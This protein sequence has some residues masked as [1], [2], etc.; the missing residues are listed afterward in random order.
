MNNLLAGCRLF[1]ALAH[2]LAG[3]FILYAVFPRLSARERQARVQAWSAAMLDCLGIQLRLAGAPIADR[4]TLIAANHSSWLDITAIHAACY[5]R[6]VSKGEV[7]QWPIVGAMAAGA[8]TLFITRE[9]RRD[10]LR[11]VHH[12]A[13]SL[14]SGDVVA[15]FPEGTTS[16]G[17][18]LLPFHANLFQAAI[19]AD[20]PVQPVAITFI[21]GA[22][23]QR[24][25]A[26][27]YT[28]NDTL[29]GSVWRTLCT[30]GIA[31]VIRFGL[32]QA[33]QGRDR[34]TWAANVRATVAVLQKE[35]V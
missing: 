9:S 4:G 3:L 12:M 6:F 33:A 16:D 18:H 19:S 8:G 1:R 35:S 7:R 21:D 13:D 20:A 11:V 27:R 23:G 28:D 31:V 17:R 22:T 14:R 32:P 25:T 2:L 29:L 5:C 15:I 30:P 26:P 24:S 10:A 34:R